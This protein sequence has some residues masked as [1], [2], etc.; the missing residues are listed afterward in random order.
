MVFYVLDQRELAASSRLFGRLS[1]AKLMISNYEF[2]HGLPPPTFTVSPEGARLHGWRA[3]VLSEPGNDS[4]L[5]GIRLQERWDSTANQIAATRNGDSAE[6]FSVTE[7]TNSPGCILAVTGPNSLW[8]ST[9]GAPQGTIT[10]MPNV[11][12][13]VAVPASA[14]DWLEPQDI[15]EAEVQELLD[16]GA[17]IYG[18]STSGQYGTVSMKKGIL[19]IAP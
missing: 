19:Y 10:S 17:T 12:I 5:P 8:N 4:G 3:I 16:A 6:W 14:I 18:I 15:Q 7:D 9:T 13:L 2:S 11:V 1:Q